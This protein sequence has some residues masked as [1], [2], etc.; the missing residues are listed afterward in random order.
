MNAWHAHNPP[1]ACCIYRDKSLEARWKP[2]VSA[3]SKSTVVDSASSST[4]T[5]GAN[6]GRGYR[7]NLCCERSVTTQHRQLVPLCWALL[8]RLGGFPSQRG[9]MLYGWDATPRN[10]PPTAASKV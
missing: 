2:P 6:G 7:V 10:R 4:W 5:A 3:T 9:T 8:P 1:S